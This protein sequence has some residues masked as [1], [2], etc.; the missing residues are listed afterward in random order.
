M[1]IFQ[2]YFS[3]ILLL[4]TMNTWADVSPVISDGGVELNAWLS[5]SIDS[6][7]SAYHYVPHQQIILNIEVATPRWFTRGTQISQ[8]DIP[9]VL[10]KKRSQLATN[11]TTRIEG[12]T[13]SRQR[14][15]I[16]LYPQEIGRYNIPPIAVGVQTATQNHQSLSEIIWTKPLAF[17]VKPHLNNTVIDFSAT[18]VQFVQQWQQ[19]N[20]DLKIGDAVSR[21]VK[22]VAHDSLSVLLPSLI[23]LDE[24][25]QLYHY[26]QPPILHDSEQRGNYLSSR[27]EQV[28]YIVQQGGKI[29]LPDL[30]VAWW[31]PNTQQ[32]KYETLPGITLEVQHSILSWIKAYGLSILMISILLIGGVWG[33]RALPDILKN[34]EKPQ[35]YSFYAA[36]LH[37]EWAISRTLIYRKLRQTQHTLEIESWSRC[38][39]TS[40][41]LHN[42]PSMHDNY[43]C[44]R[45]RLL[46]I[47]WFISFVQWRNYQIVIIRYFKALPC[48]L[49]YKD[50]R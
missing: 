36:V 48:L 1:K 42:I 33:Y 9:H 49:R 22:L 10:V 7:T 32:V 29:R 16:A 50:K 47:W 28:T 27:Q 21:E 4:M 11:Y 38:W 2:V 44:S 24:S 41:C 26:F 14:W 45:W 37:K 34:R 31:N 15:E 25:Q 13:W 8:V 5:E 12:Q 35:W 40:N 6:D 46:Q 43:Q 23:S 3:F 19:S 30:T 20:K 17:E 39:L 18:N